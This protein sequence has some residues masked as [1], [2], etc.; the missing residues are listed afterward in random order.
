MPLIIGLLVLGSFIIALTV[1][2][3]VKYIDPSFIS[4]TKYNLLIAPIL[5]VANISLGIGFIKGHSFYQN[6]P[7]MIAAQTFI[8]Y[9]FILFFSV[10]LLGDKISLVKTIMA[11]TLISFSIWLLKS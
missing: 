1:S 4:V 7:L 9:L 6:L 10:Y 8:Y 3:Q 5:L 11:F 2:W